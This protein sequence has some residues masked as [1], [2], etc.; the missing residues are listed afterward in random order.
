[1]KAATAPA[2]QN[3]SALVFGDHTLHLKQEIILRRAADRAVQKNDLSPGPTK[4]IDHEHLMGVTAGEPIRSVDI[5]ALDMATSNRVSQTLE[6]R[7]CQNRAAVAFIDIALIRLEREA[8]GGDALAQ[9]RD[10]TGDRIVAGLA[11]A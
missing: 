6:G 2:F 11:L 8:I 9:R 5:N 1:M 3:F 10:L 4:L 7:A